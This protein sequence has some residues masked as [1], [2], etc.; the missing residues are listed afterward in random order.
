MLKLDV[1]VKVKGIGQ[2]KYRFKNKLLSDSVIFTNIHK[3]I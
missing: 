3:E 1:L 2:S